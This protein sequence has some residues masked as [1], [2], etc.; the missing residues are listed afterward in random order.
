MT[1]RERKCKLKLVDEAQL[2]SSTQVRV[3]EIAKEFS[4]HKIYGTWKAH[5]SSGL[6]TTLKP[7]HDDIFG[8]LSMFELID[9]IQKILR[10]NH[11]SHM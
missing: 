5:G 2:D 9:L 6:S 8:I 4:Y 10:G 7:P 11:I 3:F 1:N